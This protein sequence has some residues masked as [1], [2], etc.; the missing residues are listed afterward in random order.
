MFV[1]TS[2]YDMLT[3]QWIEDG[4]VEEVPQ[5]PTPLDL[6]TRF[7][8]LEDYKMATDQ[9][10]WRPV[11]YKFLFG[12]KSIPE[13]QATFKVIK[14]PSTSLSDGEIKSRIITVIND[15]FD[16]NNWEF[17][18]TF[19]FTELAAYIHLQMSTVLSSVVIVPT[20]NNGVFGELFEVRCDPNE[21]FIST[22]QVDDVVII[23][24]NTVANLRM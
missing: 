4:S 6:R 3:R 17:G 2:D 22:A 14:L 24:G 7:A 23:D 21:M 16:V 5:V 1:L 10:I 9:I 19:F 20:S 13:L 18:E 12:N 11:K 15:Y 8:E